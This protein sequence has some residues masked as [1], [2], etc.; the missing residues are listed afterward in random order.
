MIFGLFE[1]YF[2]YCY[3]NGKRSTLASLIMK[4][5]RDWHMLLRIVMKRLRKY[6][7]RWKRS[8]LTS[9]IG[10]ARHHSLILLRKGMR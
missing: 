3:L 10:T 7:S 2:N 9:Q 1:Y 8:T 5:E 4:A 6:Y